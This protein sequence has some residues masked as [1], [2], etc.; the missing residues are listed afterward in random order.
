MDSVDLLQAG[1]TLFVVQLLIELLVYVRPIGWKLRA[2]IAGASMS[3]LGISSGFIVINMAWP[4]ALVFLFFQLYRAVNL[5]RIINYREQDTYL[6]TVAFRT[7]LVLGSLI[8]VVLGGHYA[9]EAGYIGSLQAVA[10]IAVAQLLAASLL[11]ANTLGSLVNTRLPRRMIGPNDKHLP[12]LTVAI[13]ARNET[14]E[15]TECLESLLASDYPKLEILVLDDC[16]QDDTSQI[17]KGF[18]HRGVRFLKGSAPGDN[19]LAKN[20]AYHQLFGEANGQLVLFCGVDVRV[21]KASLGQLVALQSVRG[22]SM[23][24]VLPRRRLTFNRHFVLQPMRYWHELAMPRLLSHIPP[25]LST[26]WLVNARALKKAG[27]FNG[28]K[29]AINPERFLARYFMLRRGYGF[30]RCNRDMRVESVKGLMQQWNTAVRTRYPE[31]HRRLE[32]ICLLTLAE[33]LVLIGPLVTVLYGLRID[34]SIFWAM[35]LLSLGLLL[36]THVV[37]LRMIGARWPLL[38]IINFPL[39]VAMELFVLNYSMWRYEFSEVYW[40]GR[41][42]C[43][44]VLRAIP[45][46]PQS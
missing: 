3:L 44:P 7:T 14:A 43:L 33:L 22:L 27:G 37:I 39:V 28:Y 42:V 23:V 9:Y 24:S 46:L 41:N 25:V 31:T 12:T 21:Q 5:A 34:S 26:C 38:G 15:L 18:A 35:G 8:G 1:T 4:V 19:W 30:Y 13:P 45:R 16:S 10:S 32:G 17:I 40:K 2:Y 20:H 11:L 36:L 6:R 29:Q